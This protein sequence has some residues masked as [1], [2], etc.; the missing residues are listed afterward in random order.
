M[1]SSASVISNPVD[2]NSRRIDKQAHAFKAMEDLSFALENIEKVGTRKRF[3]VKANGKYAFRDT[4]NPKR[5]SLSDT[6]HYFYSEVQA[7]E[8]YRLFSLTSRAEISSE[9]V[10]NN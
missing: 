10:Q 3:T 5:Y 6:P 1:N 9:I 4:K 7:M 8:S 2:Q